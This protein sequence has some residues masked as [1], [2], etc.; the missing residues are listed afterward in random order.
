MPATARCLFAFLSYA[1]PSF[2]R[3][4]P[5]AVTACR[6]KSRSLKN[7]FSVQTG[8]ASPSAEKVFESTQP[9]ERITAGDQDNTRKKL[10]CCSCLYLEEEIMK[11]AVK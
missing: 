2:I 1:R 3:P 9:F 8:P 11:V 7:T 10:G 4:Q 5:A 6:E